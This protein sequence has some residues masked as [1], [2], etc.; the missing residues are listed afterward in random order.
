MINWKLRLQN[1][2]TLTSLIVLLIS[3]VYTILDLLGIIPKFPQ[4]TVVKIASMFIDI[5]VFVGI[6]VDPTTQG[7]ED[8]LRAMT[9]TKPNND[10]P[11]E[12]EAKK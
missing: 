1:K 5:L 10:H 2:A 12:S 8:S 6:I 7:V 11:S 3:F 9:Y 4:D